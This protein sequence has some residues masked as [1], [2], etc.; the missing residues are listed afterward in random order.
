MSNTNHNRNGEKTMKPIIKSMKNGTVQIVS[1]ASCFEVINT[2]T[3]E[4]VSGN[5]IHTDAIRAKAVKQG[6]LETLIN[7]EHILIADCIERCEHTEQEEAEDRLE[8]LL[9]QLDALIN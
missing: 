1:G 5:V 6:R 4:T 3:G 8:D 7:D 9:D 2:K